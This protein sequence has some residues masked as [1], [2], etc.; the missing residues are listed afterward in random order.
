MTL[1]TSG[2]NQ[3]DHEVTDRLDLGTELIRR[4]AE[5][6]ELVAVVAVGVVASSASA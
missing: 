2:C 4:R 3:L 6:P 1:D 5:E